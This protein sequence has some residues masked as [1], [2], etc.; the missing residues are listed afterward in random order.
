MPLITLPRGR[1]DN[2][3]VVPRGINRFVQ[4]D[5]HALQLLCLAQDHLPAST[6]IV[7]T[8]GYQPEGLTRRIFRKLGANIFAVV[9]RQRAHETTE[10]FFHNGH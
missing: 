9:Y 6:R 10:I 2:I 1:Y 8:R 3:D 5:A 4:I 7:L